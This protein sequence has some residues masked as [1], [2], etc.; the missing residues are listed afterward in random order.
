MAD[1]TTRT[2]ILDTAA[3]L[4][5]EQGFNGTGVATILREAGVNSGSLYHFFASKEEL[6]LD[7]LERYRELLRPVLLEPVEAATDDPVERVF[8]LL[9][10][11]RRA[12]ETTEHRMGC[13]IGNLALEV[14]DTHPS[15]RELIAANFEGW[16]AGVRA[17]LEPIAHRFPEET[18]LDA[19]SEFVLT[20]MEGGV[21]QARAYDTLEPLERAIEQLRRY[22]ELLL[23]EPAESD[24]APHT[25]SNQDPE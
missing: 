16:T 25:L 11:Y 17:W 24:S 21:M 19:L 7:V 4:F 20:V 10:F 1:H 12:L 8:T 9:E 2:R 6:L 23:D 13:P 22:F 3:R 14:T 15:T 18:D 5:H